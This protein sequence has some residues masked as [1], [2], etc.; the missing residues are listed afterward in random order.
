MFFTKYVTYEK[1]SHNEYEYNERYNY[2]NCEKKHLLP[3]MISFQ[4]KNGVLIMNIHSVIKK[5][6]ELFECDVYE[7]LIHL[8]YIDHIFTIIIKKYGNHMMNM[9]INFLPSP[10]IYTIY[11]LFMMY[12]FPHKSMIISKNIAYSVTNWHKHF[13][14]YNLINDDEK[15]RKMIIIKKLIKF[16][17]NDEMQITMNMSC[18]ERYIYLFDDMFYANLLFDKYIHTL[19][20]LIDLS[21]GIFDNMATIDENHDCYVDSI[22]MKLCKKITSIENNHNMFHMLYYANIFFDPKKKYRHIKRYCKLIDMLQ[23]HPDIYK[24]MIP[25]LSIDLSNITF[26]DNGHNYIIINLYSNIIK[27]VDVNDIYDITCFVRYVKKYIRSDD[28][29][30]I[31]KFIYDNVIVTNDIS[32]DNKYAIFKNC[33]E[34]AIKS[35]TFHEINKECPN[36]ALIAIVKNNDDGNYHIIQKIK[37]IIAT[38]KRREKLK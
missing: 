15:K 38:K 13:I 5:S 26:D 22:I 6:I 11:N 10:N 29:N 19:S 24:I 21:N 25:F 37:E 20:S 4:K 36:N 2:D 1:R 27:K 16:T 8:R 28:Y 18:L 12:V 35:M 23:C 31:K 17:V 30:K 33:I 7:K 32:S 9:R 14:T 34:N 3:F